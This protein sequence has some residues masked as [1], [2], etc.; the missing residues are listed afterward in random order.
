ML[1]FALL[2]KLFINRLP[3]VRRHLK[4]FPFMLEQHHRNRGLHGS[5]VTIR[6]DNRGRGSVGHGQ[7]TFQE[8]IARHLFRISAKQNIRSAAGHVGGDGNGALAA[9]RAT[10]RDS[11]SC[12]LAFKTWCVMPAFFKSSAMVSDFS[13]EIVPTRTG[14]PR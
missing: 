4:H 1:G 8:M 6:S 11:R 10:M 9:C 2:G 3:L 12:C 13:M 7:F 5:A 14:C